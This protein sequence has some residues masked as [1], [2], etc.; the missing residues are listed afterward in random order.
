MITHRPELVRAA[1]RSS[2]YSAASGNCV[3][4]A[5]LDHGARAVRDSKNSTGPTLIFA[6]AQWQAFTTSVRAGQFD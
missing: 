2:S 5:G 6:A 1:W 4:Y 3:Q